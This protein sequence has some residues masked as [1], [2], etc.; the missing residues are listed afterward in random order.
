MKRIFIFF[1][2]VLA[3]ASCKQAP[4]NTN[5]IWLWSKFMNEVNL[6]DLHAKAI[7][8]IILQEVAF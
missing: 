1:A 4:V 3:L 8:N 7:D 5:G 6:D 2:L